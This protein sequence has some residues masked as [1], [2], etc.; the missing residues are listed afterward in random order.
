MKSI[1]GN[2][3]VHTVRT[4]HDNDEHYA[5]QALF[6]GAVSFNKFFL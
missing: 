5:Q 4:V 3:S 2:H 1:N 6:F